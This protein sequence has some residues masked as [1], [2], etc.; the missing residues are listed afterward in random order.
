MRQKR[1]G[2]QSLK[3][4]LP[5]RLQQT[6]ARLSS[7]RSAGASLSFYGHSCP[8]SNRQDGTINYS[9]WRVCQGGVPHRHLASLNLS[10]DVELLGRA[11]GPQRS[12]VRS[13]VTSS[14]PPC[15]EHTWCCS[16]NPMTLMPATGNLILVSVQCNPVLENHALTPAIYLGPVGIEEC[17]VRTTNS[18]PHLSSE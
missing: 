15:P 16:R 1:C 9:T 2:P 18:S 5:G 14:S 17:Q 8:P 12:Q 10:L 11:G 13:R 6:L 7:Q 3:Y 4:L